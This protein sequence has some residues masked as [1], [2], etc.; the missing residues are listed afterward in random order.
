MKKILLGIMALGVL[1]SANA[2]FTSNMSS[3]TTGKL[4]PPTHEYEIDTWGSNS[5]VYEFTPRSNRSMTCV[6][7]MNDSITSITM[8]CFKKPTDLK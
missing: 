8:Q 2:F 1:T 4:I 7:F 6:V 3:P 5:E